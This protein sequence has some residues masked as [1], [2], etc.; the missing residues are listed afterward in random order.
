MEVHPGK[1]IILPQQKSNDITVQLT[2]KIQ[3]ENKN[4][5]KAI[6]LTEQRVR[7]RIKTVLYPLN[8]I[9]KNFKLKIFLKI[10][11]KTFAKFIEEE[12]KDV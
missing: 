12:I 8:A 6:E 1:Q 4:K 3:V 5:T 2:F 9:D 10:P 7:Q 11:T